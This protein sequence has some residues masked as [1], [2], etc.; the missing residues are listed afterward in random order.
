LPNVRVPV[1]ITLQ[2]GGAYL[3]SATGEKISGARLYYPNRDNAA[4]GEHFDF[5]GYD[6]EDRGWFIYGGPAT[7]CDSVF[8]WDV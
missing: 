6:P 2:P 7:G 4:P 3:Y 8:R 5:W 1:Y